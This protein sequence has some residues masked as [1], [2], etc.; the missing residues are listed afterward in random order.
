MTPSSGSPSVASRAAA[1]V[2]GTARPALP[3]SPAPRC[4]AVLVPPLVVGAVL[5]ATVAWVDVFVGDARP[6]GAVGRA[7]AVSLLALLPAAVLHCFARAHGSR[8]GRVLAAVG[9]AG[10]AWLGGILL[11]GALPPVAVLVVAAA[12]AFLAPLI[13]RPWQDRWTA[14]R[15][16]RVSLLAPNVVAAASAVDRLEAVPWVRIASV[17]VPDADPATASR[18]LRHPV[19][20]AV[21]GEVPLERR[22]IV[23][24]PMKDPGVG[25]AIA[26]LVARGHDLTSESATLRS[27]EG[28]VDSS[29][30]DPLNLLMGR[31]RSRWLDAS[32]RFLD[33]VGSLVLLV[34]AAPLLFACAV[35]IVLD[36]GFPVFYRQRRVGRA[37]RPFDVIK[38][39]S[40]RKDAESRSGPVWASEGD[41]R[42]TRV[43]RFLR[44][45]RLDELPQLWNVLVGQ[46][47]LVGPRPER[48][49]F[50]DVLR[51]Q[52]PLFELRTIVRP[53]L[54]GWAQVRLAYGASADDARAK[55]EYD[56]FYVMRRSLWFDVAILAETA[57]VVL[58]GDGSR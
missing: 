23:C 39:R 9:A 38:F 3:L 56:L 4:E 54:T 25:R 53:G 20:A 2:A 37:G 47:A 10:G 30:A 42:I 5:H 48:P 44:R 55:L 52:V 36:D 17:I 21:R 6:A 12:L 32:S 43:G 35:A 18:L 31:P 27:A 40:M 22:V 15:V 45:Y 24:S 8:V 50:C 58:T 19:T 57:R 33:I 16:E 14:A 13:W 28:R 49:H 26:E 34:L 46:M 29:R 41:P 11:P 1:A 51:E 7:F